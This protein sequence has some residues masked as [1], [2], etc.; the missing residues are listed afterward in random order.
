MNQSGAPV[1]EKKRLPAD[2]RVPDGLGPQQHV[3]RLDRSFRKLLFA[4]L[5]IEVL[6]VL[7]DLYFQYYRNTPFLAVRNIF[8]L[9]GESSI[10]T[11]FAS[12]Q[13]FLIGLTLF[14]V[15]YVKGVLGAPRSVKVGWL[16]TGSFF[17]FISLDDT[18]TIHETLGS[19]LRDTF[20]KDLD[21]QPFF[22]RWLSS[23]N[24]YGWQMFVMP[25]FAVVGLGMSAFLW[26]QMRAQGL[27]R[28]ILIGLS[29]YVVAIGMDFVEGIEDSRGHRE[30]VFKR[31]AREFRMFPDQVSHLAKVTEEFLEMV[32]TSFILY[33]FLRY[34]AVSLEGL[35]LRF[36]GRK[37][38]PAGSDA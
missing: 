29:L 26:R 31:I 14:A 17:V 9:A 23:M 19:V 13:A 30:V 8:N 16:L 3:V 10:P 11:W 34:L 33:G 15:A 27:L 18:A 38:E 22:I 21:A 24:N 36:G 6:L 4:L 7:G 2:L 20:E 1:L 25:V 5:A 37:P 35:R 32:G 12:T 28:W